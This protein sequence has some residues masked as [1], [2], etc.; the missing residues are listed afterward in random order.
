MTLYEAVEC[1]AS[2]LPPKWTIEICIEQGSASVY[3]YHLSHIEAGVDIVD[4]SD[5]LAE[6]VLTAISIAK[7][8]A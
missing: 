2:D 7:G 6:Q 8:Q 3:L 5:N 1:A 4:P